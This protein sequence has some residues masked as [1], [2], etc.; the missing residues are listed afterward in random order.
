[1]VKTVRLDRCM[2]MLGREWIGMVLEARM[3]RECLDTS[4]LLRFGQVVR[5]LDERQS[6]VARY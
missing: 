3:E 4:G 2:V 6:A 5:R 1:M